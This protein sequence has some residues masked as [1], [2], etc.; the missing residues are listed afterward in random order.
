MFSQCGFL[1]AADVE[2]AN[3][4]LIAMTFKDVLRG[5]GDE[6]ALQYTHLEIHPSLAFGVLTSTIP[7]SDHNQGECVRS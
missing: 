7:A 3:G 6:D 2:E 1:L 4:L 5:E